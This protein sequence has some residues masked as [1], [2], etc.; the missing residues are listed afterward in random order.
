MDKP[1]SLP[2]SIPVLKRPQGQLMEN[3]MTQKLS[4]YT[5]S[6]PLQQNVSEISFHDSSPLNPLDSQDVF[7]FLTSNDS[8]Y[9]CQTG[10]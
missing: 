9:D 3:T 7:E 8:F 6:S 1:T 4:N 5:V 10:E 2:T